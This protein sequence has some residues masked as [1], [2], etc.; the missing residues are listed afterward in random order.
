ML[1]YLELLAEPPYFNF[2][3]LKV[4]TNQC[5]RALRNLNENTDESIDELIRKACN[6]A[7][8]AADRHHTLGYLLLAQ[9][10]FE[11]A[12]YV[13][14]RDNSSADAHYEFAYRH[15]LIAQALE[16]HCA[17]KIQLISLGQGI[18]AIN[19]WGF[20][21]IELMISKL[22]NYLPDS[23]YF[24]CK[25]RAEKAASDA[26][27]EIIEFCYPLHLNDEQLVAFDLN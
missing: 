4:L 23:H 22:L 17:E 15:L 13:E 27:K 25:K 26:A 24:H 7:T 21:S 16:P 5:I 3:A 2:H 12:Q 18:R 14:E 9:V 19:Q 11:A 1:K 6:Y 8:T 10:N 20:E